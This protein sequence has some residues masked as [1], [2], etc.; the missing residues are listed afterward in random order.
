MVVISG[1]GRRQIDIRNGQIY[2]YTLMIS[3]F[4]ETENVNDKDS[5]ALGTRALDWH[6][7]TNILS[8]VSCDVI[9][10]LDCC[11]CRGTS[12][13][14]IETLVATMESAD[15]K[16]T[17]TSFLNALITTLRKLSASPFTIA[18]FYERM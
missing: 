18:D 15:N 8:H 7:T 13:S 2:E 10:I 6:I 4:N 14:G 16:E 12:E 9:Q 17:D 1:H 11:Y 5:K 3:S